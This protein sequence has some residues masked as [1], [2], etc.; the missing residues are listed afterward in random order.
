MSNLLQ[1]STTTEPQGA[2]LNIDDGALDIVISDSGALDI[3]ISGQRCIGYGIQRS[4]VHW[5]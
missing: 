5:I 2:K 3:V 4:T 1:K